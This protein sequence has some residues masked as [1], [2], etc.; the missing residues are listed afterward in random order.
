M[1]DSINVLC[2]TLWAD[3]PESETF[4]RLNE[5]G[6]RVRVVCMPDSP[7]IPRWEAAGITVEK[8]AFRRRIDR[9]AIARLRELLGA[10]EYDIV[11][12]LHN[13]AVSNGLIALRRFPGPAVIA[14]RGIVGNVSLFDPASWMRYL[15]P[16]ID[17]VI[18][19]ADA[20]RDFFLNMHFLGFRLRAE[21]FVTIHKGHDLAWYTM[22]PASLYEFDLPADAFVVGCV[23]NLRPRKGVEVLVDAL[24]R[25]PPDLPICLLLVGNMESARLDK[26]I[27]RNVN[28]HRI[29][30]VG[31]RRDAPAL[32]AA[33]DVAVLPALRREGLPK[34]V[35]EAM[36]Y[37]V[38]P[39]VTD[40]GGS[41][42]LVIHEQS[43]LVVPPGDDRALAEALLRLYNDADLRER[44]GAVARIRLG[45]Q[46]RIEDTVR[47]TLSLYREV[48]AL[49][50]APD[51]R[52]SPC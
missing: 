8:L 37:G 27:A 51:P 50:E 49:N 12:L 42:E 36:A 10:E 35:I 39:V 22:T 15:N 21:K 7:Y 43:G 3:L 48:L 25:L 38:A 34:T 11:H 2:V 6:C 52:E 32:I 23:A 33:C 20:I 45:E 28:A 40:V 44:L 30:K 14:Y 47:K 5:L 19:V 9:Q 26:A 31:F 17:R 13:K 4:I 41:A 1:R 18:C 29:R 24:G 16:R 46:F